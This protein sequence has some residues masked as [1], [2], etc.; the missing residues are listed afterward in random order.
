MNAKS[1]FRGV[2]FGVVKRDNFASLLTTMTK[3][4]EENNR[5]K[6]IGDK[7]IINPANFKYV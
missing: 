2:G 5:K 1:K 4:T 7:A 6:D 3:E